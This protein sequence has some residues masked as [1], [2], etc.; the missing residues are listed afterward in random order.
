MATSS[1]ATIPALEPCTDARATGV[2]SYSAWLW[3][4]KRSGPTRMK[5]LNM[6]AARYFTIDFDQQ[7]LYYSHRKSTRNM[8]HLTS[9]K[10]ILSA[11]QHPPS[12][13]FSVVTRHRT[14]MLYSTT[15]V[16]AGRWVTALHAARALGEAA[17]G[18]SEEKKKC[19]AAETDESA[20]VKEDT[21]AMGKGKNI[22]PWHQEQY[23]IDAVEIK[24]F[25]TEDSTCCS[26]GSLGRSCRESADSCKGDSTALCAFDLD[27]CT[28]HTLS[29]SWGSSPAPS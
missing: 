2:G 25:T 5:C 29:A 14:F 20:E 4:E 9:F 22:T 16:D 1:Y 8:S 12:F 28:E 24:T 27:I 19:M 23:K 3:K 15:N 11:Q 21:E 13:G 26:S 10:D 17:K 7:I 6:P 18:E